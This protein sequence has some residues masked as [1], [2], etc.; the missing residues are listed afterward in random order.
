[1]KAEQSMTQIANLIARRKSTNSRGL[2]YNVG[3]RRY[4][5]TQAYE[6]EIER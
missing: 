4:I 1:M 2:R 3:S 5:P 6:V